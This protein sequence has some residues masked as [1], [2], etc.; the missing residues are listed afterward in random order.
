MAGPFGWGSLAADGR[1]RR[2]VRLAGRPPRPDG[3]R[4]Y[5]RAGGRGAARRLAATGG[6]AEPGDTTPSSHAPSATG[7][8]QDRSLGAATA[9][10]DEKWG[11]IARIYD[12]EHPACRGAELRF[13]DQQAA[14]AG[15]RAIELASGTGRVAIA[16]ARRGHHVTGVE[17]SAGMLA[18]ASARTARLSPEV[19]DHLRWVHGD[20]AS[21][22]LPGE[23]FGL[24]FVAF[25]SFWLLPDVETQ[26]RC[27]RCVRRHLAPG[28]R[29][30][31]DVFPP[32]DDDF[33]DETGIGQRLPMKYRGRALVRI[34]DYRYDPDLSHAHSAVRYY[35]ESPGGAGHARLVA[36]FHYTLRLASPEDVRNLLHTAGFTVEET[37]GTYTLDSL[38]PD[39]PRAI[40]VCRAR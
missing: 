39:S 21:F 33:H 2:T 10:G 5:Q 25:N 35:G 31:L 32:V 15:G 7:G 40:F 23:T 18:R 4:V 17:L 9:D 8:V 38:Q 26:A 13:W 28:G 20:M 22:H 11:A 36:Q 34:K 14:V 19:R 6:S 29:F 1:R 16:L 30:V 37:Y 3:R 24:I 12:L 27:L